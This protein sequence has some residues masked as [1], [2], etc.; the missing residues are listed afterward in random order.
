MGR[1]YAINFSSVAVTAV[2]DLYEVLVP[3]DAVMILHRLTVTQETEEGDAQD[4]QLKCSI[5]RVI[6]APT[7]GSGG[8]TPTPIALEEG[9]A[10]A[11]ITAET[12]NDTQLTGGTK[13]VLHEEAWN[14]RAGW[15]YFPPPEHRPVFSPSTRCLVEL[16]EAPADSVTISG[17]MVVEELGG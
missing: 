2:Q 9:D 13:T 16:E 11:G 10:A 17:T 6:G 7:S 1:K 5:S 8:G 14:V 15:D 4:E 3:A 12:N